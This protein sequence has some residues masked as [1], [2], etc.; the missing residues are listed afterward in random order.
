MTGFV[1]DGGGAIAA[2]IAKSAATE[3]VS[4]GR[5]MGLAIAAEHETLVAHP[6]LVGHTDHRGGS[7]CVELV[8]GPPAVASARRYV[9]VSLI[10]RRCGRVRLQDTFSGLQAPMS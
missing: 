9:P 5:S 6:T 8:T 10:F 7:A 4:R 1:R 3:L 2:R